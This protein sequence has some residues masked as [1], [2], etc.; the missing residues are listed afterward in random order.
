[1]T[2]RAGAAVRSTLIAAS[3]VVQCLS[4]CHGGESE[5]PG[6]ASP[7]AGLAASDPAVAAKS[8]LEA[9][10]RL[11]D[12]LSGAELE[13]L[14][15]AMERA[16]SG[17]PR[18]FIATLESGIGGDSA[19]RRY[20]KAMLETGRGEPLGRQLA[21]I[22][23][24]GD[25]RAQIPSALNMS[26]PRDGSV[27]FDNAED[28]GFFAGAVAWALEQQ[29]DPAAAAASLAAGLGVEIPSSNSVSGNWR[30]WLRDVVFAPNARE[31]ARP[32]VP[33]EHTFDQAF[34]RV[35]EAND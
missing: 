8:F 12:G 18:T 28:A 33:A 1:M 14:V 3:L 24:G 16:M 31:G 13:P 23:R 34:R 19:I 35:A 11:N 27:W 29:A 2:T 25:P 17:N 30:T 15:S 22:L 10:R 21:V 20:A 6:A 32:G 9:S 5:P 7:S 4:A 26:S